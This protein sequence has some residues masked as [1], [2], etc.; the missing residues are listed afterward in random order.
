MKFAP[1]S[2]SIT[3]RLPL[4]MTSSRNR[5]ALAL[6]SCV[7]MARLRELQ[8]RCELVYSHVAGK[9]MVLSTAPSL[10][11]DGGLPLGHCH[12]G[13]SE[14]LVGSSRASVSAPARQPPWSSTAG[15]S[16]E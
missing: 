3:E 16:E 8:I 12:F 7:P 2:S 15:R 13:H 4:L 14:C 6:F 11:W 5:L 9:T 10:R 1:E